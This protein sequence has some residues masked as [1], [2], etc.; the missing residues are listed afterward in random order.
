LLT[1][2][3]KL[4]KE[5]ELDISTLHFNHKLREEADAEESFVYNLSKKYGADFIT[6]SCDIMSFAKTNGMSIE[7]AARFKRYEFFR[8]I[9]KLHNLNTIALAHTK[10][11]VSE[12]FL[13]NLI[14]GSSSKGLSSLKPKR[15]FFIRP[16]LFLQKAQIIEYLTTYNIDHKIDNSNF[17]TKFTRNKI[18]L[19]LIEKLSKFN[20][21]IVDTLYKESLIMSYDDNFLENLAQKNFIKSLIIFTKEKIVL[22]LE[23]IHN[24]KAVKSRVMSIAAKEL[25]NTHYSLSFDNIERL[26]ELQT[27]KQV[28]LRKKLKAYIK[29]R[30]LIMEKL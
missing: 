30:K 4:K 9:K 12:T 18:R 28:V 21:N 7:E 20:P 14:R 22:D 2:L 3:N 29:N 1:I 13:M 24:H 26:L 6:D 17:D 23:K 5:F 15:D 8:K 16:I 19:E 27:S 11:D 25:L 10:N